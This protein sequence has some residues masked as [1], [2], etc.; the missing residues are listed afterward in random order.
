MDPKTEPK[1][2][3]I[4]TARNGLVVR[5]TPRAESVGGVKLRAESVG[6]QL[7][8]F[9]II[10]VDGVQ[11]AALIPRNP[12]QPEWV[13]VAEAGG[14]PAYVDVIPLTQAPN[15][16][17]VEAIERLTDAILKEKG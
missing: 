2:L 9:R 11:Y 3:L 6:A 10:N 17:L 15:D 7:Y 14:S 4:V 13:R 5:N 12:F 16:R 1:Y 8:A